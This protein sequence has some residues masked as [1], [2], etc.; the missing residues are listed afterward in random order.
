MQGLAS[1]RS[2]TSVLEGSPDFR[3]S[4]PFEENGRCF[5]FVGGSLMLFEVSRVL[6]ALVT[7]AK[8]NGWEHA[9]VSIAA[10]FTRESLRQ[11]ELNVGQLYDAGAFRWIPQYAPRLT[12]EEILNRSV[13]YVFLV[14]TNKCNLQCRYCFAQ[15][16]YVADKP[17]FMSEG[18][19]KRTLEF[20]VDRAD[21]AR[22]LVLVLWGGE[23]LLN[24]QLLEFALDYSQ[25]IFRLARKP[26]HI[27]T[28]TNCTLLTPALSDLLTRNRVVVNLSLDGTMESHDANRVSKDG[29]GSFANIAPKVEHIARSFRES[30]LPSLPM[31]RM[32]VTHG[33]VRSFFDNHKS[34]WNLG[35]PIT[36]AKD[37]DWLPED[38]HLS[39]TDDDFNELENQHKMLRD[40]IIEFLDTP[41]GESLMFQIWWDLHDIHQRIRRVASCGAGSG[42]LTIETNGDILVCYHLSSKGPEYLLGNVFD[43]QLDIEK[44]AIFSRRFVDDVDGCRK[45][46]F[47]YLCSGGCMAKSVCRDLSPFSCWSGQC[48][49]VKIYRMHCLRMYAAL[50]AS[51]HSSAVG[52]FLQIPAGGS[53]CKLL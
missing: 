52:H 7:A 14:L 16:T 3:L 30:S 31:A 46:E 24:R 12:P 45:C 39:L 29:V 5:V 44:R 48:R 9:E 36:W 23:P 27:S 49:F 51:K 33:T 13:D 34:I 2:D 43:A 42:T 37:V 15:A 35:V 1:T 47:K 6:F 10:R 11:A 38:S 40:Y 8:S 26:L 4:I 20:L 32:T 18:T 19:L 22:G 17:Q 50:V 28:V 21:V 25:R 53:T 41:N